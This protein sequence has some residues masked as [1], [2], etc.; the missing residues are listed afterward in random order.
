MK[1]IEHRERLKVKKK[2]VA[3]KD[4]VR[5]YKFYLNHYLVR[6]SF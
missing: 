6:R 4:H 2:L 1:E 3:V 5:N